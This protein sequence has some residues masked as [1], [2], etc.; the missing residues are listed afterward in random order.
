MRVAIAGTGQIARLHVQAMAKV[1]ELELVGVYDVDAAR[2]EAFGREFG[3]RVFASYDDLLAAPDV[4]AVHICTPNYLHADQAVAASAAGKHVFVEKPMALSLPDCDRMI[5]AAEAAGRVLMVGHMMRYQPANQAVRRLIR[6]GAVGEVKHLVRHRFC[7][8][9]AANAWFRPW[10]SDRRSV[11]SCV[12]HGWGPHDLDLLVWYLDSPGVRVYAQGTQSAELY[13]DQCDTYSLIINH[14]GGAVSALSISNSSHSNSVEQFIIGTGGSIR[15]TGGKVWLNGA[16]VPVEGSAAD[17]MPNEF[18][19][20]ARCCREGG[21]PD[22]DG[23]SS[24][25]TMAVVEAALESAETNRI[26]DVRHR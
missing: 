8:F 12:L 17:G 21:T 14:A 3:A 23:R 6:E 24:R 1:P 19:E 7:N 10:Y 25:R 22:A 9:D 15:V 11:G 20:F 16:E 13:R 26:V 2:A 4:E 5:A 18:A